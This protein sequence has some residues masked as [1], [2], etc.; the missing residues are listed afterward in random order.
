MKLECWLP[1]APIQWA[2]DRPAPPGDLPL[3]AGAAN[4]RGTVANVIARFGLAAEAF[5][6]AVRAP[7]SDLQS[8]A[9]EGRKTN[10]LCVT[11]P[12]SGAYR[13]RYPRTSRHCCAG[14]AST[15]DMC[16]NAGRAGWTQKVKHTRDHTGSVTRMGV[17]TVRQLTGSPAAPKYMCCPLVRSTRTSQPRAR[18][19]FRRGNRSWPRDEAQIEPPATAARGALASLQS[20]RVSL[21]HSSQRSQNKK[22]GICVAICSIVRA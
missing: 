12:H 13:A 20:S 16:N 19:A 11:R 2:A 3:A 8:A 17:E 22:G 21:S 4:A 5:V 7:V 18:R 10:A 15:A 14:M 1:T 6:V 9:K